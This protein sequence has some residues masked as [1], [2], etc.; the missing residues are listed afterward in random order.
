MQPEDLAVSP[1]IVTREEAIQ[2]L[3]NLAQ[4]NGALHPVGTAPA[5]VRRF[6]IALFGDRVGFVGAPL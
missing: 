1:L 4:K 6:Q 5:R 3:A 2:D